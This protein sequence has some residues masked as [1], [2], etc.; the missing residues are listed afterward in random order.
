MKE[1]MN[2][3]QHVATKEQVAAGVVEPMDK[4]KVQSL[5]IFNSMP[6]MSEIKAKAEDLAQIA[7]D[8]H[9]TVAMIG[10]APYLMSSLEKA[11][12]EKGVKPIYAFSVRESVETVQPDGTVVKTNIFKH[13]G[14]IEA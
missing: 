8:E 13:A 7:V 11:L 4:K 9:C 10:G 2:L 14:F 6:T 12:K 1:I 3:T 5:L